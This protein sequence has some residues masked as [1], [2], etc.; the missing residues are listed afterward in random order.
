MLSKKHIMIL[1]GKQN[2]LPQM[3]MV[4]DLMNSMKTITQQK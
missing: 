4:S 1:I 3:E 2:H